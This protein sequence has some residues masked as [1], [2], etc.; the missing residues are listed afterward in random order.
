[1]KNKIKQFRKKSGLTQKELADFLGVNQ[2]TISLYE[3]GVRAPSLRIGILISK[4]LGAD[5]KDIFLP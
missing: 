1:M 3:R 2:S 5:V 4:L